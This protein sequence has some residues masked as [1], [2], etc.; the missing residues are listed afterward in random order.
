MLRLS[1][2]Y[3]SSR[4]APLGDGRAAPHSGVLSQPGSERQPHCLEKRTR[5]QV[6]QVNL[7]ALQ[8]GGA[9][10]RATGLDIKVFHQGHTTQEGFARLSAL[11]GLS[12]P[13]KRLEDTVLAFQRIGGTHQ[14]DPGLLAVGGLS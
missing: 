14:A 8:G 11:E 5:S 12:Y 2:T 9:W 3:F 6:I 7:G 4:R 10:V 13:L 1:R